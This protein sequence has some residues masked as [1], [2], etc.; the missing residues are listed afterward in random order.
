[1][2]HDE[3]GLPELFFDGFFKVQH[4][5]AGQRARREAV[6]L[7]G[8]AEFFDGVGQPHG[9]VYIRAGLGV[10]EDGFADRQAFKRLAQV[11]RF[12]AV[13]QL[14]RAA[15]FVRHVA[16]QGFGVGH[17]VVVVPPGGVELHHGE[18][19]VVPHADAFVAVAPVDLEHA[20]KS[21]HDQSLEVQLGRDAQKHFLIE[22]VMVRLERLGVG[23]ARNRVKHRRFDFQK[24][25]GHHELAQAAHRL[26][27]RHKTLARRLV[28]DQVHIAL[29]VFDFL[30][31]HAMKLVRQR[32]QAFGDEA[33][34]G[35]VDRQ[36]ACFGFEQR[37]FSGHDVAQVPVFEGVVQVF[38]H[39]FVVDIDLDAAVRGAERRVLDGCKAGLA[40]HT[41]E[42]H[43][44]GHIH[45]DGH[46]LELFLA[47][48][49]VLRKQRFGAVAGL[50]VVGE[51]NAACAQGFEF[52]AALG[53]QLVVVDGRGG[54][55]VK[56]QGVGCRHKAAGKE[57]YKKESKA[58]GLP[59]H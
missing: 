7:F 32:A 44:A 58:S 20:L 39:A 6:F 4:L 42:H 40:H 41:L 30:V 31:G 35:G 15:G 54:S 2:L 3:G 5:Q 55:G 50:D 52:F 29:A 19:G 37:A 59:K 47:L 34:A 53:H 43:A 10:F 8:A 25:V 46:R 1:M 21:A 38:A 9:V 18:L 45:L 48:A 56:G 51:C 49:V 14:Q 57:Q 23:A 26:A 11:H 13:A 17:Q 33:Q 28:G 24:L 36:L 16:Y 22:R 12:A 27:A